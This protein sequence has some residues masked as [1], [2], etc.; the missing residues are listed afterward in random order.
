MRYIYRLKKNLKE[1]E[2][3]N[4]IGLKSALKGLNYSAK[5]RNFLIMLCV[6]LFTLI[7][8]ALLHLSHLEWCIIILCI[9]IVLSA[10]AM[11]TSIELICDYVNPR[12]D[13]KIGKIKDIAAGSV[14]IVSIGAAIIGT[15]ILGPHLLDLL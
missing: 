6:S 15:I 11:N 8:S 1:I 3:K 13:G 12:Y 7:L 4:G 9:V 14:L 2:K 10:E 5:E